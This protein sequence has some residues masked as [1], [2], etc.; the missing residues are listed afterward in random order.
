M[1]IFYV[2]K[3]P[4]VIVLYQLLPFKQYHQEDAHE[5]L[6]YMLDALQCPLS[7]GKQVSVIDNN[8]TNETFQSIELPIVENTLDAC[9]NAYLQKEEVIWNDKKAWKHL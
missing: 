3:Y 4:N 9:M 1:H 5:L 8:R 6:M 2:I 7:I